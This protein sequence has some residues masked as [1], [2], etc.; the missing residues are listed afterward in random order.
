MIRTVFAAAIGLLWALPAFAADATGVWLTESKKAH[1]EI[2]ACG[3]ALCGQIV[4]LKEPNDENG[5]PKVDKENEDPAK[6]SEPLLGSHM[7]TGM[8]PDEPGRWG[9]GEIYN[10]EDGK[11]YNSSME[12]KDSDT[13]KVAGCVLIFCKS[14]IWT[15]VK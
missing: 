6:R 2:K 4:W 14:Q 3:E 1:V 7:I 10:A 15:R 5:K 12:L 8:K 9:D 13:L 11:T